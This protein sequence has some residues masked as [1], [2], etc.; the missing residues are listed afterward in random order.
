MIPNITRG[1][2]VVG[3]MRYLVGEGRANEHTEQHLVAGDHAI[4]ARHGYAVL[5]AEAAREIGIALD[6]PRPRTS[7][8]RCRNHRQHPGERGVDPDPRV[9]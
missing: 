2:R 5:D 6:T 7:S 3:L 9:A 4:M 1:T 8:R